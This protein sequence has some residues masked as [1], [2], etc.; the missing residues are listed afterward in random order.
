MVLERFR[1]FN[2]KVKLPKCVIAERQVCY[3]GNVISQ[4][5]I[6]VKNMP[7]P[8]ELKQLCSLTQLTT[9]EYQNNFKWTEECDKSF[10]KLKDCFAALLC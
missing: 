7:P 5:G 3:L 10:A 6:V 4:Q 2:L 9:K 1:D 8:S